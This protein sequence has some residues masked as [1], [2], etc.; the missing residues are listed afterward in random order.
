M[1]K[2]R[3]DFIVRANVDDKSNAIYIT[4]IGTE[5]GRT[6]VLPIEL[7]LAAHHDEISKT[8]TFSK[9]KSTLKKRH[10]HRK[11]WVNL[12]PE[13]SAVYLDEAENIQ[14]GDCYL[15]EIQLAPTETTSA[16]QLMEDHG[17]LNNINIKRVTQEFLLQKFDHTKT[18]VKQW[19]TNFE[20]ECLRFNICHD[21][22]KIEVLKFFLESTALDWYNSELIKLT[23]EAEWDKWTDSF[24]N[25]FASKGWSY[26]RHAFSFRYQTG[27][28][29][30][31]TLKKENLLL[32]VRQ[33]IDIGTL[34]DL[35]VMGLPQV[36]ADKINRETLQQPRDLHN[37][38]GKL[39][40][41]VRDAN[42]FKN[43]YNKNINKQTKKPCQVCI[44]KGKGSRY[45][46]ETE[47]RFN[48]NNSL[49]EAELHNDQQKN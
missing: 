36:V 34:I 3:F 6:Y 14:F 20:N 28:L 12:T 32:N 33:T 40:Y 31:Y 45:H 21:K 9:I 23:I 38:I 39:E 25:T 7:Q 5:D 24:C 26:V 19:I 15:E 27:S 43:S 13:L 48:V 16:E 1:H 42:N 22:K 49:L 11:I 17:Q 35:I 37:E 46:Q 30:E 41:L 2:L 8:K 10:Q 18:N 47:C 44:K 4:S 29:L